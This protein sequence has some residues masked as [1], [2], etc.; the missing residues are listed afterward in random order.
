MAVKI[1]LSRGGRKKQ[2][3][4]HVVTA[5][6]RSPRDGRFIEKLGFWNPI[7]KELKWDAERVNYWLGTG[8]QPTDRVA[9]IILKEGLGSDAQRATYQKAIDR[10]TEIVRKRTEAANAVKA[11]EEAAVKAEE[12]EVAKAAAA[13]AAA[14]ESPAEAA[15]E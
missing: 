11:A 4:Y 14:A 12:A 5:D 8:A 2:P 7:T 10:G 9:K 3:F 1:R 15:A 13:E 6:A